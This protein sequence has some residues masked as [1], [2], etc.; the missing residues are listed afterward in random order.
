M[1]PFKTK[2]PKILLF[3]EF[4]SVRNT[5]GAMSFIMM[6]GETNQLFD[7]LENRQLSYLKNIFIVFQRHNVIT[8]RI[9]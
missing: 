9:S 4:K 8:S 1:I 6:D 2:L 7:I 3:D 5:S